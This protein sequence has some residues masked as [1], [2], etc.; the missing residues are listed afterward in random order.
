MNA[1]PCELVVL[2]G[3]VAEDLQFRGRGSGKPQI[4]LAARPDPRGHEGN[5]GMGFRR[6]FW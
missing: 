6:Y 3:D 2:A 5:G 1:A 4:G